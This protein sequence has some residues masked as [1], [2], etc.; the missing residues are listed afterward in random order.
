MPVDI[1]NIA[2]ILG[3]E[4]ILGPVRTLGQLNEIVERGLPKQSLRNLARVVFVDK[5]QQRQLMFRIVPE[6]TFKR[7][8]DRLSPGESEKTERLARVT[9]YA[10]KVWNDAA[11]AREFLTTAHPLLARRTPVEAAAT[12]LG[13]R[14][15][16]SILA[17]IEHGLPV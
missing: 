13:A 12:D 17:S 10:N 4:A 5:R 11:A 15:V 6:A 2:E 9:A 8:K 7:R 3:G 14:Q 16:E 1:G